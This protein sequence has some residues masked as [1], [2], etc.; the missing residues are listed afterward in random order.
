[1]IPEGPVVLDWTRSA[2]IVTVRVGRPAQRVARS[3][4]VQRPYPRS[5]PDPVCQAHADA[6]T[7]TGAERSA[8]RAAVLAA[9]AVTA[10]VAP[11]A[12]TNEL[13]TL[14]E[15]GPPADVAGLYARLI[16]LASERVQ[17]YGAQLAAAYAESGVSALRTL[18]HVVDPLTGR[19]E[20]NG[21][22]ATALVEL[23]RKER[24]IL[25]RLITQGARLSLDQRAQDALSR[26]GAVLAGA[27]RR[28]A[29]SLGQDWASPEV[30]RRAQAALLE[31]R[32]EVERSE[33]G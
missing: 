26:N 14:A 13:A 10:D 22:R 5:V 18:V 4:T 31:A 19:L 2:R 9:R 16:T 20:V 17:L 1:M 32:A 12:R 7:V 30:R 28:L 15:V 6:V 24:E 11:L 8:A 25:E 21:E 33:Q 29:E 23:E 3:P 27:M